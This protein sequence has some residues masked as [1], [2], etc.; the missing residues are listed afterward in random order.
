LGGGGE[1]AGFAA[2]EPAVAVAGDEGVNGIAK[3]SGDEAK[4][5][6]EAPGEA[7]EGGDGKGG[8]AADEDGVIGAG[9]DEGV[10][11]VGVESIGEAD[12]ATEIGLEG[13][14]VEAGGGVV[15][16]EELDAGGAEGADAV[17]EDEM[18]GGEGHGGG[19][20]GGR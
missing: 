17:E 19:W 5:G 7:E 13:G 8:V 10:E 15:T 20:Q 9:V 14:E 6:E 18:F 4:D 2:A 11:L 3:G 1:V 16:E 12:L